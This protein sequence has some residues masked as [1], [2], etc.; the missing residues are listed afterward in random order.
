MQ[1][2]ATGKDTFIEYVFR[3]FHGSFSLFL[4][5]SILLE[6]VLIHWMKLHGYFSSISSLYKFHCSL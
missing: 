5:C 3:Y 2:I 6:I 4:R 1:G